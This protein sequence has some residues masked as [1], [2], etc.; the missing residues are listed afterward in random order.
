MPGVKAALPVLGQ[1][2]TIIGPKGEPPSIYLGGPAIRA[3]GA[4]LATCRPP[5]N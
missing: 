1:L 5:S 4:V 3:S 2:A